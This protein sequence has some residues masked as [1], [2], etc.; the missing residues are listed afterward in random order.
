MK[1]LV[2]ALLAA[3]VMV[4][5]AATAHAEAGQASVVD[6][7]WEPLTVLNSCATCVGGKI[8][9]D[10]TFFRQAGLRSDT[11][12]N[13]LTTIFKQPPSIGQSAT[14]DTALYGILLMTPTAGTTL[15]EGMD[16][17][18]VDMQVSMDGIT[19][20]TATPTQLFNVGT[21]H[22]GA[23]YI[24]QTSQN[25]IG[26]PIRQVHSLVAGATG[27]LLTALA[28]TTAPVAK[29]WF[30]Y[31]LMRFIVSSDANGEF[32]FQLGHWSFILNN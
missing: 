10:S 26:V 16:S 11:T 9:P 1:R 6:W 5:L 20:L 32:M 19:W 24:S 23:F 21:T 29:G 28:T 27:D 31:P 8:T 7:R 22:A 30:G 14:A 25:S 13:I 4:A 17:I 15:A 12:S 18:Y 2:A 3:M